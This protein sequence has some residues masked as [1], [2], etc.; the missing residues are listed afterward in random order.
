MNQEP[1]DLSGV[2]LDSQGIERYCFESGMFTGLPGPVRRSISPT[3]P[4][5]LQMRHELRLVKAAVFAQ[6]RIHG[7]SKL[8]RQDGQGF[9]LAVSAGLFLEPVLRLWVAFEK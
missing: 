2:P 6:H 1:R 4:D 8:L 5:S 9:A 3:P 7:L